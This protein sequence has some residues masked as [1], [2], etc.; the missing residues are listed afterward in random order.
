VPRHVTTRRFPQG[1]QQPLRDGAAGIAER[2]DTTQ[3]GRS[4]RIGAAQYGRATGQRVKT[5]NQA[6]NAPPARSA[7][8]E[9]QGR[10]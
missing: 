10:Q 6:V 9:G 7:P 3:A 8:E 5:S 1:Q 4:A 2:L